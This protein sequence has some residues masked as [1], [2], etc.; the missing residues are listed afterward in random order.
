MRNLTLLFLTL[1]VLF[2]PLP[3]QAQW[4]KSII[5]SRINLAVSVDAVDMVGDTK[6]DLLVT[7]FSGRELLLYENNFPE[8]KRHT[9]DHAG[10]TFAYSGDV[11]GDDDKDAIACVLRPGSRRL[12]WYENSHPTW[13]EHIIDA[14]T[15]CDF[16]IVADFNNDGRPDVFPAPDITLK[17][18]KP[19]WLENDHPNW[20]KHVIESGSTGYASVDVSDLDGD[21]FLDVVATIVPAGKVVWLR[22]E[23]NGIDW[24]EYTIDSALV[25][26]WGISTGDL[27]GDGAIDVVAT[28]GGSFYTGVVG[29]DVV[30]YE[31][32]HPT[33]TKHVIRDDFV[34]PGWA[35]PT[36][37]NGD[38]KLDLVITNRKSNV[39]LW[40]ENNHPIWPKHTIDN[41]L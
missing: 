9:I 11:D 20:T 7:N 12:V 23:G 37:V 27:N 17:A 3:T 2:L 22:N 14:S 8:W 4:Q 39:M 25:A 5:D 29:G 38:D 1:P 31:N 6:L 13:T 35:I 32:D 26:A 33:W 30:W 40:L 28:S 15:D 34:E 18:T 36:D 19:V 24:T 21:G 10:A 16:T 41:S